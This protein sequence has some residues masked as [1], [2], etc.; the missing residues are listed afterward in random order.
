MA[1]N[2]FDDTLPVSTATG[3]QC[4]TDIRDNQQ[5][6]RDMIIVGGMVGWNMT[7]T[8]VGGTAEQPELLTYAKS[9]ER[10]KAV[11]TW[12]TSG[13][14]DGNVTQAIYSYSSDSGSNYDVIGTFT[15]TYDA[16]GNVTSTA[17]S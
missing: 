11:L 13:G 16:D 15:P 4:I 1:Y 17:W 10:L 14:G 3:P 6:M 12:G 2:Q 7:A 9:T 8:E 5:A